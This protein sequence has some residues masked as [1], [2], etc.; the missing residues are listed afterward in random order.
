MIARI[1]RR[2]IVLQEASNYWELR[3]VLDNVNQILL[4]RKYKPTYFFQGTPVIGQGGFS[5]IIKLDRELTEE[6]VRILKR[7]LSSSGINV[8]IK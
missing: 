1:E 7:I 5:V 8:V 2:N 4:S 3:S 6:D